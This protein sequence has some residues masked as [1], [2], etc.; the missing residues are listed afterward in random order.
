MLFRSLLDKFFPRMESFETQVRKYQR[1]IDS[2]GKENTSL[3]KK[4]DT[5][6]PSVKEQLESGKL[7]QEIQFF[8]QF[9]A[10]TPDEYKVAYRAL[11]QKQQPNQER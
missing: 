9:Y 4:L 5:T 6:K 8:R 1:E 7:Q 3:E 2:L 11:N 10:D